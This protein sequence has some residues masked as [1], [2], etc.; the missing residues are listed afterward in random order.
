MNR[1]SGAKA[2]DYVPFD[3][4]MSGIAAPEYGKYLALGALLVIGYFVFKPKAR[5]NPSSLGG[6]G[7]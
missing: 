6:G 5:R 4:G 7:S 2:V 1:L 3:Q